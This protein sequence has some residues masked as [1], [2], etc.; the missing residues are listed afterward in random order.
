MTGDLEGEAYS[1]SA[2]D[3]NNKSGHSRYG[4]KK[5]FCKFWVDLRCAK[6]DF[7]E[8]SDSGITRVTPIS[9]SRSRFMSNPSSS[10]KW[11][12]DALSKATIKG[13]TMEVVVGDII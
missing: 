5:V 4:C 8:L 7:Y 3:E 2:G 11:V 10:G 12:T 1:C 9:G 6:I 13:I